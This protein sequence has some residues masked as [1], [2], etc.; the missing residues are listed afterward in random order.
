MGERWGYIS[1]HTINKPC[2]IVQTSHTISLFQSCEISSASHMIL[3]FSTVCVSVRLHDLL[4][5]WLYVLLSYH[6]R[7]YVQN[8]LWWLYYPTRLPKINC[9]R[10]TGPHWSQ[11]WVAAVVPIIQTFHVKHS[12]TSQS[13]NLLNIFRNHVYIYTYTLC[14]GSL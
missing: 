6:T 10:S 14:Q 3:A 2:A 1:S 9:V 11:I 13:N 5:L 8:H 7:L 12:S 4:F